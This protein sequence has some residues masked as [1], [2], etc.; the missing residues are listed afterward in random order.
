MAVRAVA[1]PL[2][3]TAMLALPSSSSS[4]SLLPL[5]PSQCA[6]AAVVRDRVLRVPRGSLLHRLRNQ[7]RRSGV[8]RA[9]GTESES[10]GTGG[11]GMVDAN[12]MIL[13]KR[14]QSLRTQETFYDMPKEWM[15]WERNAYASYRADICLLLSTIES[16]LLIMRPSIA[17]S[18]VS[19]SLAILPVASLLFLTAL[20][21]QIWTLNCALLDL[22]PSSH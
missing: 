12:M 18:V 8:V 14:I 20:G 15:E 22:I 9:S 1:V 10:A 13:R 16:Q 5:L 3:G 7:P 21:T 6:A 17:L 2:D 4:S 11:S 19:M